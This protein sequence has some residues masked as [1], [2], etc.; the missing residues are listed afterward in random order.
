MLPLLDS[1]IRAKAM[2]SK[3]NRP[4]SFRTLAI[5][6]NALMDIVNTAQGK[7]TDDGIECL[8]RKR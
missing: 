8:A 1:V 3:K 2:F 5:S 4:F 7:R 6:D